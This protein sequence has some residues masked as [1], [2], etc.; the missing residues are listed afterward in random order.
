MTVNN[1]EIRNE[2]IHKNVN[3]V[4]YTGENVINFD[5]NNVVIL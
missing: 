5:S 4:I 1:S 2:N 3:V